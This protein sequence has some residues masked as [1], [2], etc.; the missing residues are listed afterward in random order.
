M[1]DTYFFLLGA[2]VFS[3]TPAQHQD[4]ARSQLTTRPEQFFKG[5]LSSFAEWQQKNMERLA[6]RA[7]WERFFESVDVFLLPT[8]FTAAFPHDQTHPDVRMI[9]M[10]EGGAASFWD[11][12]SYIAPAT[13]TGCPATTAPVGLSRSGLPVG[14]QIVGPYL[15]D[16]TAIGFARLLAQEVGGF[17]RPKGYEL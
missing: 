5:A 4:Q 17:Q 6:Y 10:P 2:I 16:A 7:M 12:L 9:P 1:L 8:T 3:L 13:L 15:E 14:L 11:L